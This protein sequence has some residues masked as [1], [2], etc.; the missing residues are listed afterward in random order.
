MINNLICLYYIYFTFNISLC[1]FEM[2]SDVADIVPTLSN[3]CQW[4]Q[5]YNIKYAAT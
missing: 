5:E 3:D 4:L 1:F 2:Y